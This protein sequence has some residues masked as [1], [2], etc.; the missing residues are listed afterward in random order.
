MSISKKTP[1]AEKPSGFFSKQDRDSIDK[2]GDIFLEK[3]GVVFLL[4]N[5]ETKLWLYEP[6]PFIIEYTSDQ[7][8]AMQFKTIAHANIYCIEREILTTHEPVEY[9]I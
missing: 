5:L 1:W 9:L 3:D 4:R 6:V 2:L 8:K 7:E